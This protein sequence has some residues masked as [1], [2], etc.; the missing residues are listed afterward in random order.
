M[1]K[2]HQLGYINAV[3]CL[4]KLPPK[5][6]SRPDPKTRYEEFQATHIYLTERVHSVVYAVLSPLPPVL[7]VN[8]DTIF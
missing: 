3:L 1:T 4:T 8:V 6:K 5:D 7:F 2:E